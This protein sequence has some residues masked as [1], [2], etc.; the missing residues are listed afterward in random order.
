MY[1]D[2]PRGKIPSI[3]LA[4][5][6]DRDKYGY[7]IIDEIL[8]GTDGKLSIKQPSLY[9]SLKRMEE[10]SLISSYWRD[11]DIGGRRHYYHLTDLGKKYLEK[12][13]VDISALFQ[14]AQ[15][16]EV[17]VL[18]QQ[19]L[20]NLGRDRDVKTQSSD[21]NV[22]EN[23]SSAKVESDKI[24]YQFD[25]FGK[26]NAITPP[27][28]TPDN[29]TPMQ[30]Q[31]SLTNQNPIVTEYNKDDTPKI[32]KFEYVKTNN[33]SFGETISSASSY[34]ENKYLLKEQEDKLKARQGLLDSKEQKQILNDSVEA[35]NTNINEQKDAT[36]SLFND[37]NVTSQID[38]APD[39]ALNIENNVSKD[40]IIP[41]SI[42]NDKEQK[43]LNEVTEK[44]YDIENANAFVDSQDAKLNKKDDG[45]FITE[46]IEASDINQN[47]QSKYCDYY[48]GIKND[49]Y[50]VTLD[51]KE[52]VKE[53]YEKSI[54]TKQ[55]DDQSFNTIGYKTY[56]DLEAFYSS[57]NIR[58]R[59]YQKQLKKVENATTMLR[60]T[61]LDFI[62]WL[63]M[64]ALYSVVSVM[65]ATVVNLFVTGVYLNSPI[66][67]LALPILLFCVMLTKL[68]VFK[69]FPHKKVTVK[70]QQKVNTN[71]LYLSISLLPITLAV[72]L[73]CG[74]TF[75]NFNNFILA[76]I[77]PV[78]I[79]LCYP[80]YILTKKLIMKKMR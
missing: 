59:R 12:W 9:S 11:S 75:N 36:E 4:V 26:Q 30:K 8:N 48:K 55:Y 68:I 80:L 31:T 57:L 20:F 71:L 41:D 62:V 47:W 45:V 73:L 5:L 37:N 70:S 54:P 18:Q 27:D 29:D 63:S 23:K 76:I 42:F 19:N 40:I 6:Q 46:R 39:N 43:T 53:L 69:K 49:K 21:K 67:Y 35:L 24:F 17:K 38:D 28:M 16:K 74:F 14:N 58:F 50:N 34:T 56:D 72:N 65:L 2:I 79:S 25:L 3:I 1:E 15:N 52:K 13:Q 66:T 51:N 33:K 10:Q 78:L 61:K 77:Y 64:F 22:E 32:S 7:E 60:I 44:N